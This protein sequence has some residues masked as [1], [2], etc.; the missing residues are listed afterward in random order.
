MIYAQY[1][2]SST[3]FFKKFPEKVRPDC[4]FLK[5]G[6]LKMAYSGDV[7]ATNITTLV[8]GD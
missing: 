6:V 8:T 2:S 7:I 3:C 4:G 5:V 1:E